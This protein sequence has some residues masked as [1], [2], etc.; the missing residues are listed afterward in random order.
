M[1]P[2]MPRRKEPTEVMEL[3]GA[4]KKH[5]ERRPPKQAQETALLS[6]VPPTHLAEDEKY[7]WEE[8]MNFEVIPELYKASDAYIIEMTVCL[9]AK[10]RRRETTAADHT[11]LHSLLHELG[12]TPSGKTKFLPPAKEEE[13]NGFANL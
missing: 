11:R 12:L 4:Y 3:K 6:S 5:P 7:I 13:V 1:I 9:I 2:P 10:M 8:L